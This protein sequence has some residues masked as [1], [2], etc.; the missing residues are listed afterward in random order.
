VDERKLLLFEKQTL[1]LLHALHLFFFGFFGFFIP[2]KK[3]SATTQ[4]IKPK[5]FSSCSFFLFF[6]F[7]F[8][9]KKMDTQTANNEQVQ[10]QKQGQ[11]E[12]QGQGERKQRV[13]I[14]IDLG[15]TYCCV[16][17]IRDGQHVEIVP[18]ESGQRTTP[19][20]VSILSA[21]SSSSSSFTPGDRQ[22]P[23]QNYQRLVGESAKLKL[24][25]NPTGTFYDM[26]RIIGRSF[27][28]PVVQE[29]MR[30]F[31]FQVVPVVS[32]NQ[33]QFAN[34]D[35]AATLL[36][37][38]KQAQLRK[39]AVRLDAANLLLMPEEI[40]AMVL[41][42]LK[43]DI[44]TFLGP[45]LLGISSS[46]SSS[47]SSISPPPPLEAVITVPAYF[48]D[49]QRKATLDAAEIAG[50]K[51][52]RF[53]NEP[54]AA[55]VAYEFQH[56]QQQQKNEAASEKQ[57]QKQVLVYDVGGGTLDVSLLAV[58]S[59]EGVIEVKRT[60]GDMHFGGE[61]FD[62]N[63]LQY[64]CAEFERRHAAANCKIDRQ[65]P[66]GLKALARLKPQ[67]EAAKK[68]L[69][70]AMRATVELDSFYEG[71]DL[72]CEISRAKFEE[73]NAALFERC[74]LPVKKVLEG[75]SPSD[76]QQVILTGGCSRIPR[77]QQLLAEF[78]FGSPDRVDLLDRTI[79]PDE[80][81]ATG[82]TIQCARLLSS[83]SPSFSTPS[84][85]Q[86]QQEP[87]L[88]DVTPLSIGLESTDPRTGVKRMDVLIPRNNTLPAQA[89]Q[90]YST[91][92]EDQAAVEIAVYEGERRYTKDCN[93][94]GSFIIQL[95]PMP[96]D[97]AKINVR[98]SINT[99][100]LLSV[101]ADVLV[102]AIDES[103]L[104]N[105]DVLNEEF[106][107]FFAARLAE[108]HEKN[109]GGGEAAT[110]TRQEEQEPEPLVVEVDQKELED[111]VESWPI[112]QEPDSTGEMCTFRLVLSQSAQIDRRSTVLLSKDE[113]A[114]KVREARRFEV[115]DQLHDEI[116]AL[117]YTVGEAAGRGEQ[118]QQK[119]AFLLALP[120]QAQRDEFAQRLSVLQKLEKDLD[121]TVQK[122]EASAEDLQ[123]LIQSGSEVLSEWKAY[124]SA[125]YERMKAA[126]L[127]EEANAL[128]SSGGG[129]ST[130]QGAEQEHS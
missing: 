123:R 54:T 114:R 91:I 117:Q 47:S 13:A 62:Q 105:Y 88:I 80:A 78:F 81:V 97:Y 79:S 6:V 57:K 65:S 72:S 75:Q 35:A 3:K 2:K 90:S 42:R 44:Q 53:I 36:K 124:A 126:Q 89:M 34:A 95:P 87:L 98:F 14:G 106:F 85:Q 59:A 70:S 113:L 109:G 7:S 63:L 45:E 115:L 24:A 93:L 28:D 15:T 73:L 111:L 1:L 37:T 52:L 107:D 128:P 21:S 101:H 102:P 60:H 125:V 31:T 30:R 76:V 127:A 11:A 9:K 104:L 84:Q 8:F 46:F 5:F 40:S 26:K 74:L 32:S 51:V 119:A 16:G 58:S 100:G 82:A 29:E 120:L 39:P 122:G 96:V 108:Q 130:V 10:A 22:Q 103:G 12:K 50:F 19:S 112:V 118:R 68:T 33:D 56:Q 18:N 20:Y 71:L 129:S 48:N 27:D 94:L 64:C 69:S 43:R 49:A 66:A 17:V 38:G 110:T 77:I 61:D 41:A 23:Q 83:S 92:E 121:E 99:S 116:V 25:S 86:Q 55:A 67:C 4:I